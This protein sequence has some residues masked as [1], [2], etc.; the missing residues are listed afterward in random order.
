MNRLFVAVR[1]PS[2]VVARLDQ[3][4]VRSIDG[5]R[6]V[7]AAQM[8]VT[9]RFLGDVDPAEVIG[10]LAGFEPPPAVVRLGPRLTRL[11]RDALVVPASGLDGV[12]NEV[13]DRTRRLGERGG[14]RPFRG[15]LTV[16][17]LRRR[18]P[19]PRRW[20]EVD[21]TFPLA[22]VE[23]I[24]STLTPTGAVHE[25]LATWTPGEGE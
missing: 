4:A 18:T 17:R 14:D 10:A 2:E 3:M 15:H 25:T 1:P 24:S 12:A 13:A 5:V 7:P 20:E 8:H 9:L 11:G 16:A 23:L 22:G 19:P 21:L 6:P